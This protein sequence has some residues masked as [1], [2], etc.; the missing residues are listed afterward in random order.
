MFDKTIIMFY[1]HINKIRIVNNREGKKILGIAGKDLAEIKLLS[2][3]AADNSELPDAANYI[4]ENDETK[5]QVLLESMIN[6]VVSNRVLTTIENVK[7]NSE[8]TFGDTGYNL[9]QSNSIPENFNWQ[10]LALESDKHARDT[11]EIV[12]SILTHKEFNSFTGN[13]ALLLKKTAD[14]AFAASIEI[15]KFAAKVICS[16]VQN[17]KDDMIGLVYMSLDRAEHY[18]EGKRESVNI[19][20]L[21]NN[22][23]FDYTIFSS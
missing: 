20:D 11:A 2:F 7:D 16:A 17:D 19:P 13:L 6:A 4:N 23:F 18:P 21:T 1:F 8:I 12:Q 3:V 9:F 5:K 10:L 22:M 14:P 15:G